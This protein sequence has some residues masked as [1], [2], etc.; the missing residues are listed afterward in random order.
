MSCDNGQY[1]GGIV[2]VPA[3]SWGKEAEVREDQAC[4]RTSF[5]L[6]VTFEQVDPRPRLAIGFVRKL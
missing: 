5:A 6:R 3:G 1:H 4:C 2:V